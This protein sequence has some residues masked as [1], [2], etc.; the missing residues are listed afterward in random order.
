MKQQLEQIS[1]LKFLGSS[2]NQLLS[3]LYKIEKRLNA[4]QQMYRNYRMLW[5]NEVCLV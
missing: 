1:E 3:A 2:F 5:L 4:V